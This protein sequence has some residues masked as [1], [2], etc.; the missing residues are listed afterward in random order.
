M[1][2]LLPAFGKRHAAIIEGERYVGKFAVKR[3]GDIVFGGA[4]S[5]YDVGGYYY[6]GPGIIEDK[7]TDEI[8]FFFL[9]TNTVMRRGPEYAL[10]DS[11]VD[12]GQKD[13]KPAPVLVEGLYSRIIDLSLAGVI[14]QVQGSE[15]EIPTVETKRLNFDDLVANGFFVRD[16]GQMYLPFFKDTD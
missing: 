3:R 16:D 12:F 2:T 15:E 13:R 11:I 6:E 14:A 4:Y 9:R 1:E 8:C 10:E 5:T 7:K